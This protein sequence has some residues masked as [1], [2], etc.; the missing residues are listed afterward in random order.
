MKVY[1]VEAPDGSILK[2]EGPENATPQQVMQAAQELYAA[3]Q[4]P[5]PQ[6][7]FD[8]TEGMSGLD[9]FR[10]GMGKAFVD[11]GRGV[12]Q[13]LPESIGGLSNAELE[14]ARR[15]DA[16]LMRT[17]AGTAGNVAGNVALAAPT[18]LIPGAATI[19]GGAAIGGIYGA[20]Q[21]GV[22]AQERVTN[23]LIG[24]AAGAVVPAIA[25]TATVGKSLVDPLYEGGRKKIIGRTIERASGGKGQEVI[26]QLRNAKEIVPGSLPTAAEAA[27]NAGIAALQRT[28]T[29]VDPVAMNQLAARQ[30][31][32]NE[33]RIAAL[34]GITP[35]V[36][37]ARAA[38]E[39]A[40]GPLYDAARTAGMD[41]NVAQAIQPRIAEL[42]Q[43]V[44]D[45]LVA[46]A[47]RL[48]R[49]EGVPIDDMGSVQGAHYLK[50][51]IDS[52]I[53]AAKKSGDADTARAFS[54]LQNE[55][56]DV[57]DQLSPAYAQARQTFAQMSPPVTQ[58]E[59]L[60]EVAKR[61]VNFRGDMTPAAFDRAT[62][63]TVAKAVTRRPTTL[64]Q[65]LSPDQMQT[66]GN[67]RADLLRSDFANT[68]GRGVGSDTVQ[69]MAFNNIMAQSGLPSA[70]QS[71]APA[72]VVGN[73]AQRFGQIAYKDANEKMAQE[74]AQAL[75][76]P[77]QAANL[78]E[79]GMVTPQ[80]QALV[81]ALRRGGA[82]VGASTPGLIQANKE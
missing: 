52:T 46:Q 47:Q 60:G 59:V 72:G 66:L 25:R 21:P 68:A 34:Q 14:E 39:S 40:A 31:A 45:D 35:D 51:V 58:G 24:G 18:A 63:D 3:R 2:I 36:A 33:A 67:I 44:P 64:A 71:F 17:G 75:L 29:A 8:P 37:A 81:N 15:M 74:L 79:A 1:K 28:A 23:T 42:M 16:P 11:I 20:L 38:R 78:L 10:A 57:L 19:P 65:V 13:Y 56:L 61:A 54:G 70:I 4:T 69:K 77:N 7:S 80:A 30:A 9:K 12:R 76:D 43:R 5:K 50:R 22:N 55:Y 26:R 53:N 49:V 41:A 82:A 73:V 6:E 27:D 62:S 32:Q 48:A